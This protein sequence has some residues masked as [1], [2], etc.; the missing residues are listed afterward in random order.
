MALLF[1][2]SSHF[3]MLM[4]LFIHVRRPN[5]VVVLLVPDV[6]IIATP[7]ARKRMALMGFTADSLRTVP[8]DGKC[9]D[10]A[11]PRHVA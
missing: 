6:L 1:I 5:V 9:F 2:S 10:N 3:H 11:F 7:A 8:P 4:Y